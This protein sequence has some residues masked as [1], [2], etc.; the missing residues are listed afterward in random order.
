VIALAWG[1]AIVLPAWGAWRV[2]KA[3][4]GAPQPAVLLAP[5]LAYNLAVTLGCSISPSAWASP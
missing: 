4:N 3:V 1:A 5:A 2:G